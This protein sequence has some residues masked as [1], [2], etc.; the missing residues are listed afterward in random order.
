LQ[1]SHRDNGA[2]VRWSLERTAQL[3]SAAESGHVV[4]I[5]PAKLELGTFSCYSNFV[6]SNKIGYVGRAC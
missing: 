3:L 4:V 2:Y 1:L 5:R 6:E